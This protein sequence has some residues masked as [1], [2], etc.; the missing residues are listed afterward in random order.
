MLSRILCVGLGFAACMALILFLGSYVVA[1]TSEGGYRI[2]RPD[3]AGPH[4]AVVFLGGCS[5]YSPYFAPKHYDQVAEK[6]R[7]KGY[8]VVFADYLARLGK[9][10]CMGVDTL[11]AAG[12]L[13]E[14]VA[15]LKSQ[16]SI[17]P[18]RITAIGWS[19]GGGAVLAAV[20]KF[21]TEQ[22]VFSRAIACYPA[23]GGLWGEWKPKV[24]V[25]MLL[26]GDDTVARPAGC[27]EAAQKIANP[28]V[29]KAVIYPDALHCFDMSELPPRTY[30]DFGTIGYHP[31]AAAAAWEEIERFLQS[32]R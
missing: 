9:P 13:L 4:P 1:Q 28:D 5:G 18:A 11:D 15:W 10:N 3:G 7:A 30:Y 17:N 26:A 24:P 27:Q 29:V 14:A 23:C 8:V 12:V 25:L 32:A 21:N 31:Q 19:F 22:L 6:F 2:F 20:N 16:S